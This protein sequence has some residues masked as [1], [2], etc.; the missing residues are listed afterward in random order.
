MP[1][2]HSHR[3]DLGAVRVLPG[4]E[5]FVLEFVAAGEQV[6][7]MELPAWALP[8]LMRMLP[9]LDAALL[10]ARGEA[11]A[12]LVAH[13]AVQWSVDRIEGGDSVAIS[14]RDDRRIDS[15]H[16]FAGDDA[17]AVHAALGQALAGRA[18]A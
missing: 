9:K 14:V 6:H 13:P 17:R 4:G 15:A 7:R 2:S 8:Q 5:G 18:A 11:S 1:F 10:Q 12:G 3:V 16:L